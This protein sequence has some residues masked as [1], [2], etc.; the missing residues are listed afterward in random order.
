MQACMCNYV[1]VCVC[2]YVCVG[3]FLIVCMYVCMCACVYVYMRIWGYACRCRHALTGMYVRV[4]VFSGHA[5]VRNL[6]CFLSYLFRV[7]L[8]KAS[9]MGFERILT[10]FESECGSHLR[11]CLELLC[12]AK[13]P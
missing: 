2:V 6:S 1:Y 12:R 4:Y 11:T 8:L 10:L 7:Q 3:L 13:H 5:F 9:E